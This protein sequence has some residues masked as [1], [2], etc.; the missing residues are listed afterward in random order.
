MYSSSQKTDKSDMV[1]S[2]RLRTVTTTCTLSRLD[3]KWIYVPISQGVVEP[4]VAVVVISIVV[5]VGDSVVL[6]AEH[7][8]KK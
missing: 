5:V 8:M 7:L 1:Y 6:V 4:W 2:T 3:F